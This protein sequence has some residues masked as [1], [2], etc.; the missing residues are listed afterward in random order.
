[1][2]G[3]VR[4][5]KTKTV[6]RLRNWFTALT[7]L[8]VVGVVVWYIVELIVGNNL[9]VDYECYCD[10]DVKNWDI[11]PTIS[12]MIHFITTPNLKARWT[13]LAVLASLPGLMWTMYMTWWYFFASNVKIFKVDEKW[14]DGCCLKEKP[15]YA[16]VVIPFIGA[17][18]IGYTIAIIFVI[19]TPIGDPEHNNVLVP[20]IIVAWIKEVLLIAWRLLPASN[21][22]KS[23]ISRRG[24]R[25]LTSKAK[26]VLGKR[27]QKFT[28]YWVAI[29]ANIL[30][31]GAG[32][33]STIAY[34]INGAANPNGGN[35][36]DEI[37]TLLA[38]L[39]YTLFA[40]I[41]V[42]PIFHLLDVNYI[43]L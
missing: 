4:N 12:H 20:A 37:N 35:T 34:F 32:L 28:K 6:T 26:K 38:K 18:H 27:Q 19:Q 3:C 23:G 13:G 24:Y 21:I 8:F 15:H 33:G 1:M 9:W 25:R 43:S 11:L 31:L 16:Q 5:Y 2:G 14:V 30:L 42:L 29:V 17:M 36:P 10:E 39:E 40:T 41:I 7:I 22:Y